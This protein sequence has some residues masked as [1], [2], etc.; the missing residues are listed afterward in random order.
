[1]KIRICR[2]QWNKRK[3]C[4]KK[5]KRILEVVRD[6]FYHFTDYTNACDTVEYVKTVTNIA[7]KI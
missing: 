2:R 6:L 4:T 1:M 3:Y 5:I 7:G